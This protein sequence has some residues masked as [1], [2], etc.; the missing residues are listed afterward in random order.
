MDEGSY[1]CSS[2]VWRA[3]HSA[4]RNLGDNKNWAPTA[5][6]LAKWCVK[7]H[8]MIYSGTVATAKLLPGDLIFECDPSG[9]NGRY[10]GIYHVDMY[11]GNDVSITVEGQK[12]YGEY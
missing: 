4:G 12:S 6:D 3:Y 5:A 8:Y 2:F 1:D 11:Q 7:N 9:A 10:E